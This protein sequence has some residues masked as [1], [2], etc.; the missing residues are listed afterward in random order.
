MGDWYTWY[1]TYSHRQKE[2]G[3]GSGDLGGQEMG[4][5]PPIE[6]SSCLWIRDFVSFYGDRSAICEWH[7]TM[8]TRKLNESGSVNV[9]IIR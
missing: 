1:F 3:V 4:P 6:T 8:E 2:H 9:S 5:T 7:V